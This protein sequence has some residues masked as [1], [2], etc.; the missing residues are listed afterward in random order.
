MLSKLIVCG[1]LCFGLIGCQAVKLDDIFGKT[2]RATPT[3]PAA[4][5]SPE[6]ELP[7]QLLA[8]LAFE[9]GE[10][11]TISDEQKAQEALEKNYTNQPTSW[12]INEQKQIKLAI[13]PIR[14][15]EQ[16]KGVYC[17]EYQA[18]FIVDTKETAITSIA[19]RQSNK[20]W[21]VRKSDIQP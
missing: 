4:I 5:A 13:T 16:E 1:V 9:T 19:C 6:I 20:L 7:H 21:I 14:T 11:F 17:R 8:E 3:K 2:E 10:H 18:S 15:M 12:L